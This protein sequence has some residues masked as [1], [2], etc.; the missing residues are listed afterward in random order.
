MNFELK[1]EIVF[2]YLG[3][4]DQEDEQFNMP[5]G[6][7]F[8]LNS[9]NTHA[10]EINSGV[11]DGQ[12]YVEFSYSKLAFHHETIENLAD[13]YQSMLINVISHCLQKE[14]IE[15]TPSDFTEND[16]TLEELAE[17]FEA[18]KL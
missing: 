14:G 6:D 15:R 4:F 18:L 5:M 12:L 13:Q 3:Q 1:P 16:M 7:Q 10:L 9:Y 8:S 11:E 17:V 2:N